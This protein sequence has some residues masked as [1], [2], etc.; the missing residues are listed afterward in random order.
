M[1]QITPIYGAGVC[2]DDTLPNY[3][4]CLPYGSGVANAMTPLTQPPI[5][6]GVTLL[7]SG[8]CWAG[9]DYI[10]SGTGLV[11]FVLVVPAVGG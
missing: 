9:N 7:L 3:Y 11:F 2:T 6:G 4:L 1:G 8:C 10:F 5:I